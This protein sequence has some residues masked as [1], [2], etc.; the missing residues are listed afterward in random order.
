MMG[1]DEATFRPQAERPKTNSQVTILQVFKLD[2]GP[3]VSP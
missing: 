1:S 2:K 3:G